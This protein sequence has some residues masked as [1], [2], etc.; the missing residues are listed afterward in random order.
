MEYS[1]TFF[2]V[3]CNFWTMHKSYYKVKPTVTVFLLWVYLLIKVYQ[4]QY[5]M[6]HVN[7]YS[8]CLPFSSEL[9]NTRVPQKVNEIAF[10]EKPYTDFKIYFAVQ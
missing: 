4:I 1:N 9:R 7:V 8:Q 2:L 10:Y 5:F 6:C 3:I